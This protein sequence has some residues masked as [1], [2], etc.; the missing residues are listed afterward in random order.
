MKPTLFMN[1]LGTSDVE[2]S[3]SRVGELGL[4]LAGTLRSFTLFLHTFAQKEC[5]RTTFALC[6][7]TQQSFTFFRPD[8]ITNMP[9]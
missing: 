9:V 6:K 5:K 8:S 1:M 4:N 7:R 3:W 2:E